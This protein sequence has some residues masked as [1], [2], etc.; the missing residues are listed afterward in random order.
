[1]TS[2]NKSGITYSGKSLTSKVRRL[3][4]RRNIIGVVRALKAEDYPEE[5]IRKVFWQVCEYGMQ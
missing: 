2:D 4:H 3:A 5:A 1:M